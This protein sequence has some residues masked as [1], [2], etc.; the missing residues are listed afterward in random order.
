MY[1]L[2]RSSSKLKITPWKNGHYRTKM[3]PTLLYLVEGED[4]IIFAASGKTTTQNPMF[5]GTWKYGDFGEASADVA[6]ESGKKNYNVQITAMGG[7]W[8]PKAVLSDDGKRLTHYGMA[9]GVDEFTWMSDEE[10][11]QFINSG[12]PVEQP[13][14]PYKIQPEN[15]GKLL[16]LSG[17]PGL[18]KST[19]GLLLARNFG[20]VYYEADAFMNHLNPYVSPEVDEPTLATFEQ[21]HLKGVPQQRI[22][23]VAEAMNDFMG[24]TEGGDYDIERLCKFYSW[25]CEDIAREQKRIGGD[26]AIA[27]AVPTREIRERIR[28]KLGPNL[29]FVV[30]HMSKEDQAARI[31]SRHGDEE[32]FVEMLTKMYDLYETAA[33]DEPN[34]ITVTI[35][36]DMTRDEVVEKIQKDVKEYK[37]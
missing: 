27:Q 3:Y 36:K 24:L 1:S 22:D 34:A 6:K 2:Q 20:Y 32:S 18:G 31:K 11:E 21:P 14:C 30:L 28:E 25:M 7:V 17:A 8:T 37:N 16:W 33:E 35:S 29:L 9:H 4:F 23:D 5:I 12:E 10:A 13:T 15:Q 26:W 19:S